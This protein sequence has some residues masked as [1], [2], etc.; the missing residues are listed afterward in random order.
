[1]AKRQCAKEVD[2]YYRDMFFRATKWRTRTYQQK[3]EAVF[4][5]KIEHTYGANCVLVISNWSN[6]Q[7]SACRGPSTMCVGLRRKLARRFDCIDIDEVKCVQDVMVPWKERN[8][9]TC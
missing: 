5:N 2:G 3:S 6:P 7:G 4:F 9:A 8:G 1:M